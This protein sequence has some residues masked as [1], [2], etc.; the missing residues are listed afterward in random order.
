VAVRLDRDVYEG[1]RADLGDLR[2]VDGRGR[3]VP[4][5]IDRGAAGQF[6][7]ECR[8]AVDDGFVP[9]HAPVRE[10]PLVPRWSVVR[11][12]RA[13]ETW[14]A[15][16]LGARYQPFVAVELDVADDRFFREVRVEARPESASGSSLR[17]AGAPSASACA[18]AKTALFGSAASRC[19]CPSSSCCSWRPS[20]DAIA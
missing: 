12:A 13:G 10:E 14:L 15:L 6:A 18:T 3:E 9:G 19:A 20:P 2:V 7:R 8:P 4:Y 11:D 17:A 16:D 1:A 5:V